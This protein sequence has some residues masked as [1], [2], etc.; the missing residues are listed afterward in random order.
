MQGASLAVQG[1]GFLTSSAGSMG[2]IPDRGTKTPHATETTAQPWDRVL[3]PPQGIHITV[4]L[5]SSAELKPQ[6]MEDVNYLILTTLFSW[7]PK[8]LQMVTA[9]MKL[10]D[11]CSLEE[12]L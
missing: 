1:L 9:A 11:A 8:S 6:Q 12:K 5:S 4:S 10:K 3:V 7:A 2:S